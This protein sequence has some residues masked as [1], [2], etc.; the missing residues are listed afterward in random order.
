[1]NSNSFNRF[2]QGTIAILFLAFAGQVGYQYA[3]HKPEPVLMAAWAFE[4]RNLAEAKGLAQEVVE[5][6]VTNIERADDL[7]IP[8]PGEPGNVERIAIEVVSMKVKGAMKGQPAQDIQVFRTAG[9][10]VTRNDMPNM[11]DAPP[12]PRGASNPP[13]DRPHSWRTPL[14]FMMTKRTR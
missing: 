14:T 13:L 4:P 1:M 3:F 8:A 11:K 7:V 6:Q 5:A 12:K 10:P 2:L 9:I